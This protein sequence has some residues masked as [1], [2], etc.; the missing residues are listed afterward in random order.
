[1]KKEAKERETLYG[2]VLTSFLFLFFL[3]LLFLV[4]VF[5][6]FVSFAKVIGWGVGLVLSHFI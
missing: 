4:F 5:R 6:L 2:F 3:M 1:M